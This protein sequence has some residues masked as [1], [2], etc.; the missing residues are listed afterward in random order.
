MARKCKDCKPDCLLSLP[1]ECVSMDFTEDISCLGFENGDEVPMKDAFLAQAREYCDFLERNQVDLK[2]LQGDCPE[3]TERIVQSYEAVKK[4]IDYVGNLG[5]DQVGTNANL[6]CLDGLSLSAAKIR[7]REIMWS[8][9][10]LSD[11]LNFTYNLEKV[12]EGMPSNYTINSISVR[13]NG[14]NKGT[15][16]TLL[17][18][19]SL[20]VGGFK[21][22]IDNFPVN[23]NFEVNAGTPDGIVVLNKRISVHSATD[24]G[25]NYTEL[26]TSDYSNN[27][28]YSNVS[29]TL[30]NEIL[31]A[32]LCQLRNLYNSLKNLQVTSC[33]GINYADGNINTVIQT[34]SAALCDIVKRLKNIGE[35]KVSY[36]S[37]DDL[38]GERILTLT[39]QDTID[40]MQ[41]DI[42]ENKE[43]I[44]SLEEKIAVLELRVEK[45]CNNT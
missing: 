45:C 42:C 5:S 19:A 18:D 13:A 3:C 32:G 30:F 41:S 25:T 31:A 34:H 11:G 26:D 22:N 39:L 12:I 4:L 33:E 14:Y 38:C 7:Q 10:T 2:F 27:R 1:A 8:T 23:V 15:S 6:Y 21:L 28:T 29:Q 35:E 17:A 44:K 20:P 24:S 9:Q 16:K 40:R 36:R 43:K 37:C